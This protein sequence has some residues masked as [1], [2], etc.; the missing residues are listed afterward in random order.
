M[1]YSSTG[2]GCGVV[3]RES[4][5]NC[6]VRATSKTAAIQLSTNKG[7]ALLPEDLHDDFTVHYTNVV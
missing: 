3:Q 2:V 4:I 6:D 1:M 5:E 7:K